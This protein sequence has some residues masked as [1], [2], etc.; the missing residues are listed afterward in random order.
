MPRPEIDSLNLRGR[1]EINPRDHYPNPHRQCP[2]SQ[3]FGLL[4]LRTRDSVLP[5]NLQ[6]R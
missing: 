2:S 3:T 4:A 5:A 1:Q 6:A